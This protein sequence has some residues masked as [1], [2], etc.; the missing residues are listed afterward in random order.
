MELPRFHRLRA[1]YYRLEGTRCPG[2]DERHFPPRSVCPSCGKASL[3]PQ[4]F[5]GRATLYA[6]TRVTQAP[7]GHA[8]LAPYAVALVRLEEGPLVAAQLTDVGEEPLP[9]GTPLEMVTRKVR[10]AEEHGLIVY[11]YKFRPRLE[12]DKR[13]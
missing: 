8:T 5:S 13:P 11:G 7:R 6:A 9:A 1:P 10:D 2:C 4:R 3:E 12:G